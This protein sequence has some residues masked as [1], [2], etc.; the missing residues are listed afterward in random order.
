MVRDGADTR[1]VLMKSLAEARRDLKFPV[2]TAFMH[3]DVKPIGIVSFFSDLV[4]PQLVERSEV[5]V[6]LQPFIIRRHD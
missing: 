1:G 4:H 5:K 3:K 6:G 2:L